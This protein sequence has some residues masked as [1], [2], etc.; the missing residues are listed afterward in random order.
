[1]GYFAPPLL[2]V[3]GYHLSG[4]GHREKTTLA[5]SAREPHAEEA[6]GAGGLRRK[7]AAPGELSFGL[8]RTQIAGRGQEA[9]P[10]LLKT[11]TFDGI[12]RAN[13]ELAQI[14]WQCFASLCYSAGSCSVPQRRRHRAVPGE[15]GGHGDGRPSP[16]ALR[17]LW[18]ACAGSRAR[19]GEGV[20]GRGQVKINRFRIPVRAVLDR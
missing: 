16:P 20:Q 11:L 6:R 7:A 13:G 3:L 8:L 19:W 17:H 14:K 10:R 18:A 5:Y 15:P 1:M 2:Q 4:G 12:Y 9:S